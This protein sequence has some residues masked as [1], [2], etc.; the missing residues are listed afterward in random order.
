MK[1][2]SKLAVKLSCSLCIWILFASNILSI[3]PVQSAGP[4][5]VVQSVSNADSSAQSLTL[6]S[7]TPLPNELIIVAV[8][9]RNETIP[10]TV[11]GND[12]NFV[13]IYNIDNVLGM[14]GITLFR[15]Q[16]PS[17]SSA[18]I[19]VSLPGNSQPAVATAIRFSNVD[20][21]G[22]DG[23]GAIDSAWFDAGPLLTNNDLKINVTTYT[24]DALVMAAA[25]HRKQTLTNPPDAG[26]TA[27]SL[28]N[29]A[30]SSTNT[31]R[32]STW[33]ERTITPGNIMLGK[34]NDLNAKGD[35]AVI[36]LSIKPAP[37]VTPTITPTFTPTPTPTDTPTPTPT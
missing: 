23:A 16:N 10:V 37:S 29:A 13:Q 33:Y 30:G 19:T 11:T 20:T 12:L 15:A 18:Q 28:N 6:P 26:E 35:W 32:L 36:G 2:K 34:D 31:T 24:P 21:S 25:W 17:P 22:I 14:G 5:T 4:I 3:Q 8:S 1:S 9:V 7:W 27:I